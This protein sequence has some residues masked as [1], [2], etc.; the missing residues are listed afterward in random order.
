MKN[1]NLKYSRGCGINGPSSYHAEHRLLNDCLRKG[2]I[3]NTIISLRVKRKNDGSY[4]YGTSIP[5]RMCTTRMLK[6]GVKK[7]RFVIENKNGS[8]NYYEA[9]LNHLYPF[10]EYSTGTKYHR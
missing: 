1:N 7:A 5:C 6:A 4:G 2:Y 8:I 3:P 9:N 10:T